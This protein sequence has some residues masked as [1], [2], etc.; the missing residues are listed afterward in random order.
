MLFYVLN[1]V[2]FAL[3]P[4]AN[5]KV[6]LLVKQVPGVVL[7]LHLPVFHLVYALVIPR[8][9]VHVPLIFLLAVLTPLL[10]HALLLVLLLFIQ[11]S[12]FLLKN[13][14]PLLPLLF[15]FAEILYLVIDV[16]YQLFPLLIFDCFH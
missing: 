4:L 6:P 5:F 11:L 13:V 14:F 15:P 16:S 7:L 12:H 2:L 10:K 3:Q 9:V 1:L 8:P